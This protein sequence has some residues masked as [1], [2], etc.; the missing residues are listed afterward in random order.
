MCR[1]DIHSSDQSSEYVL[2]AGILRKVPATPSRVQ[3]LS[4]VAPAVDKSGEHLQ[5]F[6]GQPH[7]AVILSLFWTLLPENEAEAAAT[8]PKIKAAHAVCESAIILFVARGREP[9]KD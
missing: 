1:Y 9:G 6:I 2:S 8:I 4:S 7:V 5:P 3:S